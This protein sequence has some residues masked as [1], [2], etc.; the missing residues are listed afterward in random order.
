[1][2]YGLLY[3]LTISLYSKIYLGSSKK[4]REHSTKNVECTS[5]TKTKGVANFG[6][7]RV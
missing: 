1:M 2:I 3:N 6:A 4:L 5:K 7:S